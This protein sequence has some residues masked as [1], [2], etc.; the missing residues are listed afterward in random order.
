M[1]FE[2]SD[3]LLWTEKCL[4]MSAVYPYL[5]NIF[6]CS[7]SAEYFLFM[8]SSSTFDSFPPYSMLQ[9]ADLGHRLPVLWIQVGL[10]QRE[11]QIESEFAYIFFRLPP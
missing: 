5:V 4:V 10:S 11:S 1:P 9:D 8:S 3:F 2:S 7:D 6:R